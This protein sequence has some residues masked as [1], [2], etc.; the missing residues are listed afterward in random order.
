LA[1]KIQSCSQ[2]LAAIILRKVSY[3]QGSRRFL[4]GDVDTMLCTFCGTDNSP[5]NKFCGMCGVRLERRKIERRVR[6]GTASLKCASCGHVCEA[7]T[8]F[9]GMCGARIE[10]RVA[11]RRTNEER[12]NAIAN[13]QLPSPEIPEKA[14]AAP[15]PSAVEDIPHEAVPEEPAAA[16]A[17]ADAS[18][19]PPAIFRSASAAARPTPAERPAISGPSF[20]GLSEPAGDGEY[21]LQEEKSSGTFVRTLVF[22]VLVAVVAGLVFLGWRS[23]LLAILKGP[24]P[25]KPVPAAVSP[26]DTKPKA[27]GSPTPDAASTSSVTEATPAPP[28]AVASDKS[29]EAQP[30]ST[31]P[32]VAATP[33]PAAE[34]RKADS[35][36]SD[37]TRSRAAKNAAMKEKAR[38][39]AA[40]LKPSAALLRAQDYL[41]GRNG[42]RQDCDQGLAYLRAAVQRSE[43]AAAMQMGELYANGRC[44]QQDRV[45]AYRWMNSA[46][47]KA[48][49]NPTIQA[50][51]D[52]L[53]GRMTPQERQEAGH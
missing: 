22:L 3:Y 27:E 35:T 13:V 33:E 44:V 11:E 5:E 14:H 18:S 38:Q 9:C 17:P 39:E 52:Q 37:D 32:A 31:K 50:T 42:V 12:A 41:Q 29:P 1:P 6:H 30:D 4:A 15:P 43:P 10:R 40:S 49:G 51:V 48:P 46:R 20:L 53:W 23:G 8:T 28:A 36:N 47:E 26:E 19:R 25:A 16:T 24:E 21:L 45:M 34:S 2:L 7:G